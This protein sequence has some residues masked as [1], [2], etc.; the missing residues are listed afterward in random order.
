MHGVVVDG[1]T[2][3]PVARA[4][5]SSTDQ[6]MALFSDSEGKFEFEVRVG[7]G[8]LTSGVR[9]GGV[10]VETSIY[11]MARKPGYRFSDRPTV[12]SLADGKAMAA[13]FQMSLTPEAVVSGHVL[14][15][16]VDMR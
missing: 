1:V 9:S 14:A 12:L 5:V 6:R 11:L 16:G 3:W 2:H 13:E 7:N 10:A 15:P 8:A 4:L